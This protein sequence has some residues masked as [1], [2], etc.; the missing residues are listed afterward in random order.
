[1]IGDP[2]ALVELDQVGAHTEE[3][4]LAVVDDFAG[5]GMLPRRGAAAEE[6]TLFEQRHVET[7]VG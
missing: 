1:L 2:D 6:G 3:Y 5:A 4:V 7:G